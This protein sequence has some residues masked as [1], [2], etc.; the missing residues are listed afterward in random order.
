MMTIVGN[1]DQIAARL[2]RFQT[3]LSGGMFQADQG[4]LPVARRLARVAAEAVCRDAAERAWVDPVVQAAEVAIFGGGQRMSWTVGS[5]RKALGMIDALAASGRL[6]PLFAAPDR[7]RE[8]LREWVATPEDE[9]GKRRDERDLGDEDEEIV[10]RLMRVLGRNSTSPFDEAGSAGLARA[11]EEFADRQ[12]GGGTL[13]PDL[14][15]RFLAAI[16]A[17]WLTH[18]Q[19]QLGAVARAM[20]QKAWQGSR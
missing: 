10:H 8:I 6:G 9:G 3:R 5:V 2:E 7:L 11:V 18:L 15:K 14:L 13:P 20:V 16:R 1:S 4:W 17:A 19:S 12:T